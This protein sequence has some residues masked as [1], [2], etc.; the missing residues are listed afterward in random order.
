MNKR[1]GVSYAGNT[2]GNES[3]W[4]EI[5]GRAFVKTSAKC[6]VIFRKRRKR[7]KMKGNLPEHDRELRIHRCASWAENIHR[8]TI[9]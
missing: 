7:Q 8:Q 1:E 6:P 4:I 9:F 2:A 5:L 3:A